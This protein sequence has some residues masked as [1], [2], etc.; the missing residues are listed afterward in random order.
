MNPLSNIS[1][2]G[3]S[4]QIQKYTLQERV[5]FGHVTDHDIDLLI[6]KRNEL[7]SFLIGQD[8]PLGRV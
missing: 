4:N 1:Y 2:S 5:K 3:Y 8:T 6:G 7:R